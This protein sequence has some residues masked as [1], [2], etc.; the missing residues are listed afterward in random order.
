MV[1]RR[2]VI[3]RGGEAALDRVRSLSIVVEIAEGGQTLNGLYAANTDGLVRIDI[4]AGS[5]L[6]AGEG[7]DREG[8]WIL[9]ANGP[10]PSVA[11]GAANALTHEADNHLFGWQRFAERGHSLSLQAP[12]LADA[13][14]DFRAAEDDESTS[15]CENHWASSLKSQ[16]DPSISSLRPGP[17]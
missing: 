5:N 15:F 17:L 11:T 6:V 12:Q 14:A 4:Y 7:V 16:R 9:G 13:P 3:A 10:Q 1:V 8:V 2:N